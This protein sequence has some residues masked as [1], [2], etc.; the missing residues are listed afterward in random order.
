M[1]RFMALQGMF[2]MACAHLDSVRLYYH[3]EKMGDKDWGTVN[4]R[5]R[6][7]EMSSSGKVLWEG[8]KSEMN[9]IS[10]ESSEC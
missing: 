4:L 10:K 2:L 5:T 9:S 7:T 6:E 1:S 3:A 8:I